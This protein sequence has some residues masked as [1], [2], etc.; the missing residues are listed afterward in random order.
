MP[1]AIIDN[2][3]IYYHVVG[4]ISD[5]SKPTFIFLHGGAGM[6]DHSIYVSFWSRLSDQANI[7]FVDQRGCGKS[8]KG[9]PQ[10]WNLE[11]HGKDIFSFCK[12]LGIKKPIVGGVS[13][14][15]YVAISYGIQY[16]EHPMALILCNTEAAVSKQARYKAFLRIANP[17]AANA[18]K[19][20]DDNW[21][22]STN[23]EYFKL[24][25]PYYAKKAYTP[26][27]LG[28]CIQNPELWAK[29][30]TTEHGKFDFTAQLHKITCPVLHL[31]GENDPVHSASCAIDT[32]RH[33]GENC[34]LVVI[35]NTGDPVYRDKPDETVAILS[36][37]IDRVFDK[38][39]TPFLRSKL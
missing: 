30:M 8:E 18:V 7:I 29:Y 9:D 4:D 33:I 11:Q 31:A 35:E 10:K 1:Y 6:A 37:F 26:G 36:D 27:E 32:A 16:P 22:A 5:Q 39:P 13:W 17:E 19:A 12:T 15:G 3:K 20:F 14:G 28:G 23:A 25:L 24:C 38:E 2:I 34:E 21:N